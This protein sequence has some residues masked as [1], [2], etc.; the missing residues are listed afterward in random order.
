M[1]WATCPKGAGGVRERTDDANRYVL[2]PERLDCCESPCAS[3]QPVLRVNDNSMQQPQLRDARGEAP[4]V[5]HVSAV[6]FADADCGD[7][8]LWCLRVLRSVPVSAAESPAQ[9]H[10]WKDVTLLD[11]SSL[12][13]S[14]SLRRL[15][16]AQ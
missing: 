5:A 3:D 7:F 13:Q 14:G 4:H 16:M 9:I 2:P 15:E 6:S 1:N 8:H 12:H 11:V 10:S